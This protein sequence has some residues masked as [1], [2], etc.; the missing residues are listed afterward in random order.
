MF[1]GILQ[2]GANHYSGRGGIL[3]IAFIFAVFHLGYKSTLD[4]FFVFLVSLLFSFGVQKTGSIMGVT[5]A[6]GL[7]NIFLYLMFPF[8]ILTPAI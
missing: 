8:L 1:R 2:F 7:T 6:H 3:Y 5:I 4:F